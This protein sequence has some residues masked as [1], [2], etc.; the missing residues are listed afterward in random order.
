MS[1]IPRTLCATILAFALAVALAAAA[2][3]PT[4]AGAD[5]PFGLPQ[6]MARF[7]TIKTAQA[8]FTE[9]RYLHILKGPTEDSGTLAYTAPDRLEKDTLHPTQQRMIV[10]GDTLT[11]EEL[12]KTERL[13]LADYPQIGGFIDGIRATLAGDIGTLQRIYRTDLTGT[14]NAWVLRLE[15]RDPSMLA[16]V[17]SISISGDGTRISHIKTLEHDGD[18]IDMTITEAAR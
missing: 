6:L 4:A 7:S 17:R 10:A 13:A 2:G 18:H 5:A 8:Q 1:M 9:Q 11:V 3:L 14:M 15:P 12:G 16:I